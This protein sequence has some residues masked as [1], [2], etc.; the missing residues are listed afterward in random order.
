MKVYDRSFANMLGILYSKM[1][2]PTAFHRLVEG[3][4][5]R[6]W[7]LGDVRFSL[8]SE[9]ICAATTKYQYLFLFFADIPVSVITPLSHVRFMKGF[10]ANMVE[11]NSLKQFGRPEFFFLIPKTVADVSSSLKMTAT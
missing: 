2:D 1:Q 7:S 4:P 6:P 8:T 10:V 9:S 3:L 5:L 11:E